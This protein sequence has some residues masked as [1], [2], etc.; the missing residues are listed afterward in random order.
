MWR[1][2][3]RRGV[4]LT[5]ALAVLA[6]VALIVF[7][8]GVGQ[9]A[10]AIAALPAWA[11]AG[12]VGCVA[13]EWLLDAA[14]FAMA[15]R[16]FGVRAPAAFWCALAVVNL[17]AAYAANLGPA[18]SAWM[19]TQRGMR[20]GEALALSLGKQLLFFPAALAPALALVTFA[21]AIVAGPAVRTTLQVMGL[22]CLALLVILLVLAASPER[23]IRAL[24]RITRRRGRAPALGFIAGMRRFFYERPRVLAGSIGLAL[25]N[26]AA[27]VLGLVILLRGFQAAND[28][29]TW[30]GAFLF[31]TVSQIA[32]TPGGAGV[33]E[34]GGV[35]LFHGILTVAPLAGF[36]VL[37]RFLTVH[38]PILVGGVLIARRLP[39][40]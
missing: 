8:G 17:A 9:V 15:G 13:L 4:T 37:A 7:G 31:S 23:A 3:L 26:Q 36:L 34:V 32:P 38:L 21:P 20:G 35:A 19:L 11:I 10:A 27:I 39:R 12:A 40:V 28:A 6:I 25:A 29:R 1:R 18:A 22:G 30:A 14:R 5:L 2:P 33:S 16:A 24:D